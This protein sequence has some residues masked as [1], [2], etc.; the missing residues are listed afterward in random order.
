MIVFNET[1]ADFSKRNDPKEAQAYW[2]AWSAYVG[3]LQASGLVVS[4]AGLQPPQTGTVVRVRNCKRQVQDGPYAET[5]EHL[6]GFFV[7]DVPSLEVALDWAARA[8][9]SSTGS[10]H[11]RPV[12]P[13]MA[14]AAGAGAGG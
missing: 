13:P 14:A 2:G 8:P 12:L 10:T 7:V 4:G 3:A 1:D 9:S 6:A 11:V 5:R